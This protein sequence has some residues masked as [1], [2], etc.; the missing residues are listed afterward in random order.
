MDC[1][2]NPLAVNPLNPELARH[3]QVVALAW[4]GF[5]SRRPRIVTPRSPAE[6]PP[7]QPGR[8]RLSVFL[9]LRPN[10]V[11][12]AA[13]ASGTHPR[14][15]GSRRMRLPV[16]AKMALARAGATGGTPGSPTPVGASVLGT[17][18]TSTAG[19]SP[20]ARIR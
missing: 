19:A 17:M 1:G 8:L 15:T 13:A 16:A 9:I 5:K 11:R 12:G 6:R 3:Q 10:G 20:M 7:A 14:P 2:R 18:C 4:N